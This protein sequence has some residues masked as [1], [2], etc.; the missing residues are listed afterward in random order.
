M[1]RELLINIGIITPT[2]YD[3]MDKIIRSK[4]NKQELYD[5]KKLYSIN[6][7]FISNDEITI[8]NQDEKFIMQLRKPGYYEALSCEYIRDHLNEINEVIEQAR[9]IIPIELK[10]RNEFK[11]RIIDRNV[12]E[13]VCLT[14]LWKY[15]KH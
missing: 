3:I 14:K 4:L 13:K 12:Q 11:Q 1:L 8:V 10:K 7:L 15:V 5:L 2:K 9:K 6:N